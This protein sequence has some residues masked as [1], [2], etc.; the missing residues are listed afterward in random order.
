MLYLL[1][2]NVLIRAHED[3]YPVDRVPPFWEWI[4]QQAANGTVKMPLEIYS[5][6]A[7]ATGLLSEWINSEEIKEVLLLDEEVDRTIFNGVIDR[8]YAPDLNDHELEEAGQDPFLVAYA[9]NASNR[10]V[11]T[12]EVSKISKRRGRTKVPDACNTMG[13]RWINDFEFYRELDFR[14]G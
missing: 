4:E 13:V 3:Y 9:L 8:A 7:R 1:D 6:I 10:V 2:A 11:V 5:E 14:I 12:K